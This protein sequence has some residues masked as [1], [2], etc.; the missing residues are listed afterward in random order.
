M[1]EWVTRLAV[2]VC[3]A[4]SHSIPKWDLLLMNNP[5]PES[6]HH[7]WTICFPWPRPTQQAAKFEIFNYHLMGRVFFFLQT[8]YKS[9]AMLQTVF[10]AILKSSQ[11]RVAMSWK[12]LVRLFAIRFLAIGSV[13][14]Q[15]SHSFV[16]EMRCLE[17]NELV[18]SQS[19]GLQSILLLLIMFNK[20]KTLITNCL[21]TFIF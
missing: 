12:Y 5:V 19:N 4:M 11:I 3:P 20:N 9:T 6:T 10:S 21:M 8:S 14:E 17:Q 1:G 16:L 13:R 18:S 7:S 2:W 15:K